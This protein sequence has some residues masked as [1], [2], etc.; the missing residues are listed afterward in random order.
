[1][2]LRSALKLLPRR[3][4]RPLQ[5][6]HR[7][8]GLSKAEIHDL[9]GRDD[10]MIL[11]IGCNDGTDTLEFLAEFPDCRIHCFECD[12]RP[13][14]SFRSHVSDDRCQLHEV[15]LS[16]RAGVA[17]LHMSGGTGSPLREDWDLSSSLLEPTGHLSMV[18]WI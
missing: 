4:L 15:A 3:A 9:L 17:T 11:E 1:M 16:D 2:G 13:I 7:E 18:P 6:P 10:P 12:P 8:Q 14:H 5:V